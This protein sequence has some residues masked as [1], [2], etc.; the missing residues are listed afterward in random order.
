MKVLVTGSSGFIGK[1]I[2]VKLQEEFENIEI[3]KFDIDNTLE[4]LK[5]YVNKTDFIINL[6][7]VNRPMHSKEFYEGNSDFPKVLCELIEKTKRSIPIIISSSTQAVRDNDYGLSKKIGEDYFFDYSKRTGNPIKLYRFHNVFGKWSKPNYNSV[8]STWC[9][10]ISRDIDI[11]IDNPDYELELIYIDDIMKSFVQDLKKN[12]F[13][14]EINY[15]DPVMS[16]TLQELANTLYEFKSNIKTTY[17][18]KTGDKLVNNLYSTFLSYLPLDKMIYP[19]VQHKDQRGKYTEL[20]RTLEYGQFSVSHSR[21]GVIR[22][23]HYHHS[24]NERFIV[25]YGE[26]T[27]KI[28][29][30]DSDEVHEFKMNGDN[31]EMINIV[32]GYT[33]SIENTGDSD[34][35]LIIWS[36]DLFDPEN[37]DTI[38]LEV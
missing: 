31:I 3:L 11:R 9:H 4:E 28:R 21:P 38:Y 17:V 20:I 18:P 27:V 6:A 29:K 22:G 19:M 35:I 23:R 8:V 14:N 30:I 34:M 10:N 15:V 26:A 2:I 16:I 12:R 24:K 33:H 7:G 37:P 1:N 5:E 25:I 13:N 36:N 32:P